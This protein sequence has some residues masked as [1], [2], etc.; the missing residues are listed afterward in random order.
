M[1]YPHRRLT[2]LI[3]V[4]VLSTYTLHNLVVLTE[5]LANADIITCCLDHLYSIMTNVF[6]WGFPYVAKH[7]QNAVIIKL[8]INPID[9]LFIC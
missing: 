5:P 1:C 2:Y 3:H 6:L 7:S 8:L 9:V 4:N